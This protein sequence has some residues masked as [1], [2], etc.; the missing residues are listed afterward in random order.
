[1]EMVYKF[2]M[3]LN[4]PNSLTFFRIAAIP[5]MV[6]LFYMEGWMAAWA[7]VALFT[8]AGISDYFDGYFARAMGQTSALGRFLDPI[9]DKLI[10][11]VALLMLVAFDRLEGLWVLAAVVILVREFLVA[12]LREFLGPYNVQV[13]VSKL[14][15]WKTTTQMLFIGFLIAGPYGEMLVPYAINIGNIGI[16]IAAVLTVITGWGYLKAG[17]KLIEELDARRE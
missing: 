10:V 9:A 17:L 13:P 3:R 14:A 12:G 5:V 4:L 11:G 8:A 15:K 1:M 16:T 7:N 6:V 2:F